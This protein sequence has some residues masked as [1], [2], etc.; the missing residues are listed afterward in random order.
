MS[1][2][3]TAAQRAL[4]ILEADTVRGEFTALRGRLR[5]PGCAS[6]GTFKPAKRVKRVTCEAMTVGPY[7]ADLRG[8]YGALYGLPR[9]QD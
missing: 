4:N 3:H 6:G 1:A 2:H 8:K 9:G 5:E 7:V